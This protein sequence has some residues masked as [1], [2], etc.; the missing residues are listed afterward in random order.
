MGNGLHLHRGPCN[1]HTWAVNPTQPNSIQSNSL[2][3][4]SS[5]TK[6]PPACP[7]VFGVVHPLLSPRTTSSH[8]CCRP[9][10]QVGVLTQHRGPGLHAGRHM[11]PPATS[12]APPSPTPVTFSAPTP[13]GAVSSGF[14]SPSLISQT[15]TYSMLT[16]LSKHLHLP[17]L[18]LLLL[19]PSHVRRP[20][21]DQFLP[22]CVGKLP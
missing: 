12:S 11:C 18:S 15:I 3:P 20:W 10:L 9:G 8:R 6:P 13:K 1:Q 16:Y 19:L 14:S 22:D 4:T 21:S 17:S 5:S 7:R 2:Q